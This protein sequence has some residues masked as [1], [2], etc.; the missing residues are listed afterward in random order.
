MR[1]NCRNYES[2]TYPG[3]ETVHACR[4]NMA[5][6][7]PWRCPDNC[8][9]FTVK[10]FDAGWVSGSLTNKEP[11]GQPAPLDDEAID[12]LSR[13]AEIVNLAGP[14]VIEEV[15]AQRRSVRKRRHW[16]WPFGGSAD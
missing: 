6:E 4:L 14:G 13:A 5:P 2:R 15:H 10:F 3:G 12:M 8:P 1:F 9:K 11:A 16:W 7:A